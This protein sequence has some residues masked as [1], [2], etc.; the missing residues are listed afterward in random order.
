MGGR[1]HRSAALLLRRQRQREREREREGERER[2]H[3]GARTSL[4][5]PRSA[6]R[7]VC[8]PCLA[9]AGRSST[10]RLASTDLPTKMPCVRR[11]MRGGRPGPHKGVRAPRRGQRDRTH[12]AR[13]QHELAAGANQGQAMSEPC[14]CRRSTGDAVAG[15]AETRRVVVAGTCHAWLGSARCKRDQSCPFLP[16]RRGTGHGIAHR[17]G[18]RPATRATHWTRSTAST[19]SRSRVVCAR[20]AIT[21]MSST[22]SRLGPLRRN[23]GTRRGA[24]SATTRAGSGQASRLNSLTAPRRASRA[25]RGGLGGRL[26]SRN[27]ERRT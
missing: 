2:E 1:E 12:R 25:P 26:G 19:G 17:H 23:L 3:E 15:R 13:V 27:V 9:A 20:A 4:P 14:A 24:T 11:A 22:G 18:R 8:V 10:R 16:L 6:S 21:S 7:R 5:P